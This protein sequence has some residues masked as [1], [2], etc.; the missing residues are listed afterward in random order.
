MKGS[1]QGGQ[2]ERRSARFLSSSRFGR[3]PVTLDVALNCCAVA[4]GLRPMRETSSPAPIFA[5]ACCS[6]SRLLFALALLLPLLL[7][8][9]LLLA[10]LVP[11]FSVG[12]LGPRARGGC[13]IW[14]SGWGAAA[15]PHDPQS[16]QDRAP[17]G[18]IFPQKSG[19]TDDADDPVCA[20][21]PRCACCSEL[22]FPTLLSRSN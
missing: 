7:G 17:R 22:R 1:E 12:R 21:L 4:I 20:R 2:P 15:G 5:R 9:L 3:R 18:I 19:C 16:P 13:R 10:L 6:R 11:A 14:L 8:L